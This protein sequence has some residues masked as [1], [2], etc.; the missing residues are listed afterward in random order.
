M[1]DALHEVH[2]VLREGGL[3]IDARP[4]SRTLA[5]VE[6][7][8]RGRGRRVG[9]INT[10][11]DAQGDDRTSDRAIARVKREGLFR[12]RRTGRFVHR[13]SFASLREMQ[14]Y[15]D[16][17]LR[18]VKRARWSV[19]A[20]TRRPWRNDTFTVDRAVR[21]ELLERRPRRRI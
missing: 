2:R 19:D 4:D 6:H 7:L 13:V 8:R 14:A 21:Y 12:S 10:A 17:H 1:V 9:T 18:L 5:N 20:A 11:R 3:L 15:L 16:D